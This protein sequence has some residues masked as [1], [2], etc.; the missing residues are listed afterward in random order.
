MQRIVSAA[1][2]VLVAQAA[3]SDATSPGRGNDSGETA[4]V[5]VAVNVSSAPLVTSVRL[6]V[7]AADLPDTLW[8]SLAINGGVAEGTA[9]VP[10]GPQRT[11]T[12]QALD[13]AGVVWFEGSAVADVVPGLN[14]QLTIV[15]A[16]V[17]PD[18]QVPIVGH[19]G[20]YTLTVSQTTLALTVGQ[21]VRLTATLRDPA[22][23]IVPDARIGWGTDDALIAVM[24]QLGDITGTGPGVVKAHAHW[25]DPTTEELQDLK[26]IVL[27]TVTSP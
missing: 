14:P 18:G 19:L 5:S 10:A 25:D 24:N 17:N 21:T 13:A 11:F 8:F 16:P 6:A 1:A 27:T 23:N 15:L 7:T 3:C 22:G 26:T 4:K 9:T 20:S 12:L 2:L